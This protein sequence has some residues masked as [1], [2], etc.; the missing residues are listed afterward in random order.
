MKNSKIKK[1]KSKACKPRAL[2]QNNLFK[3]IKT[4]EKTQ[5]KRK[6]DRVKAKIGTKAKKNTF[7]IIYYNC[8]KK[9]YIS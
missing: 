1:P 7:S 2:H 9:G 6:K 8:N 3:N 4:F 5:K